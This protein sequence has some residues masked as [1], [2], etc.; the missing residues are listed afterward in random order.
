MCRCYYVQQELQRER[1]EKKRSGNIYT[2]DKWQ[3]I[4]WNFGRHN[5]VGLGITVNAKHD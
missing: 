5:S 4:A 3:E 1:K 2:E